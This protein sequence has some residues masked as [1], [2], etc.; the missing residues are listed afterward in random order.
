[1]SCTGYG[2]ERDIIVLLATTTTKK[3]N[4][5]SSV[6]ID[7]SVEMVLTKST[8]NEEPVLLESEDT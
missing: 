8:K 3:E 1:M 2:V 4:A 6:E 5:C 7:D